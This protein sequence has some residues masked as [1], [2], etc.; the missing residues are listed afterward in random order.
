MQCHYAK[1]RYAEC[2]NP[3]SHNAE[4]HNA[5][6]LSVIMMSVTNPE[7]IFLVLCDPS[8]NEL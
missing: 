6:I 7:A 5:E 2:S 3:K 1:G 4:Y 8:M